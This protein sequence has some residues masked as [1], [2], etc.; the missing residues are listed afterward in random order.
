M[1][2]TIPLILLALASSTLSAQQMSQQERDIAMSHLHATRKMFLDSVAG[3]SP[4]QLSFK[5]SPERWSIAECAEHITL[6]EEL[7]FSVASD[8]VM[9]T[10]AVKRDPAVYKKVDVELPKMTVDRSKKVQAPE[11]LKPSNK[12][13]SIDEMVAEFKQRRDRSIA[14]VEK[15]DA[16]VRAHVTPHPIF[17]ELDAYQWI[18]LLSAHSERHTLQILE[19]KA[20]PNFPK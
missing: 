17:K 7:L 13:K 5:A 16:D 2:M 1:K 15:T 19:V 10:P 18:L 8:R 3:L 6:S 9:K 4:A 14:W 11:V 12:W 20:E